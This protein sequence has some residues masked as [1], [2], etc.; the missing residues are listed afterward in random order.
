MK[1]IAED[2]KTLDARE[3]ERESERERVDKYAA[4]R[5]IGLWLRDRRS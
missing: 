2:N 1:V 3:K 4:V 5:T